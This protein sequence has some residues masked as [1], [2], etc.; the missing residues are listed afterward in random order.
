MTDWLL[1]AVL[2]VLV[3]C[4]AIGFGADVVNVVAWL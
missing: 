4:A 2:A 1:C 3:T